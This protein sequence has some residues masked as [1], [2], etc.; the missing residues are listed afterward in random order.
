MAKAAVEQA[1]ADPP[2]REREVK[3]LQLKVIGI[4]VADGD[5]M[6]L[7]MYTH[8]LLEIFK[9]RHDMEEEAQDERDRELIGQAITDWMKAEFMKN[10]TR[11]KESD[12]A[13]D[14]KGRAVPEQKGSVHGKDRMGSA[15]GKRMEDTEPGKGAGRG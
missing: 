3:G 2:E 11:H 8:T 1:A 9:L 12:G 13:G 15:P 5:P 10:E 4:I 7:A 6:E 14:P